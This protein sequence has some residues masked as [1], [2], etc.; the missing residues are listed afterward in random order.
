MC[1][2][3]FAICNYMIIKSSNIK[4]VKFLKAT[5]L[6]IY[7]YGYKYGNMYITLCYS[8]QNIVLSCLYSYV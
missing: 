2:Y 5:L 6:Y 7:I 4:I 1:T 3:A 8:G